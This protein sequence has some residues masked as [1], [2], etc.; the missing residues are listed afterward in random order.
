MTFELPVVP[1]MLLQ[2][3]LEMKDMEGRRRIQARGDVMTHDGVIALL[4]G[5]VKVSEAA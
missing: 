5:I 2:L 4:G 1:S 3:G